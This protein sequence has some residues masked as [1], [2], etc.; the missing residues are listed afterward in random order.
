M[1]FVLVVLWFL[2]NYS[3][4]YEK[5]HSGERFKGLTLEAIQKL[6]KSNHNVAKLLIDQK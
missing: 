5:V 2:S 6:D 4:S 3:M 1:P